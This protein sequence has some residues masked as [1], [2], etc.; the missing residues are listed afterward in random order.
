MKCKKGHELVFRKWLCPFCDGRYPARKE[1]IGVKATY[2][3]LHCNDPKC[4]ACCRLYYE[5]M[6]LDK[7]S[8]APL[9]VKIKH[10]ADDLRQCTEQCKINSQIN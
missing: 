8:K 2:M 5:I 3:C 9:Q 7:E 4:R 1:G 6:E 10:L